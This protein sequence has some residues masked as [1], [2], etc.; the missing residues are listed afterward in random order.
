MVSAV[1]AIA[2]DYDGTLTETDRPDPE[3]LEAIREVRLLGRVV[4][5]VT[6]RILSEL[7][8]VFP[9]V[10]EEFDAI[11]A[12]NGAVLSDAEGVHDL[13]EPV[14]PELV[15]SLVHRDIPVRTGRVL[16]ACDA[17]YA[18]QVLEDIARLELDAQ[19]VRNRA[20][21][22]V[23][24]GGVTKGI[25]LTRALGNLG[26]SRHSTMAVG[27][28]ENDHHLLAVCEL[29][30]AVA[31][32]VDA[33]KR[34]ADLVLTEPNGAG[35]VELLRGPLV[36]GTET[37]PP[38]GWKLTLGC[39]PSGDP[40]QIPASQVNILLTGGSTSGKSY[41]AGLLVE[42]L[43]GMDY[44]VLVID[45]EGDHQGL[46]GRRGILGV[47]GKEPLPSPE[48]L[49]A[50]LRHRFSSVV[51]DLSQHDPHAQRHYLQHIAPGILAQRAVTGLPHWVFFD[52]AHA[53]PLG[54]GLWADALEEGATGFCHSTYRPHTLPAIV[55]DAA[56]VFVLSAG[57]GTGSLEARRYV[58]QTA[59]VREEALVR[60]L[61]AGRGH[62]VVVAPQVRQPVT[63][64]RVAERIS[65][66]VR[67][68]HKYIHGELP[69]ALRFYFGTADEPRVAANLR[70]FHRHL[71][72]C[73]AWTVEAHARRHDFSNWI[74]LVLQDEELA[75]VIGAFE[76]RLRA[77]EQPA[78]AVRDAILLAI[79][80]RYLE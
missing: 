34:R 4:V 74:R 18:E 69:E 44:G 47:G 80:G 64:F 32:A 25:G 50:L 7:R 72:T 23:L 57:D 6:G 16:L 70:E 65:G 75:D 52:E 60:G 61:E 41:V 22:M 77:G 31:N 58:A 12:E 24:P 20:A 71:G 36:R 35:I 33:L 2:F 76:R 37:L 48:A 59:E 28:A 38:S 5:L 3:V 67:H 8:T 68:W 11:V 10:D 21:L 53:L 14:A 45:L 42:Q 46:A 15:R 49:A 62:G 51:L 40:V 26:V 55:R 63:A 1:Q 17:E 30:V 43:A 13:A 66:H 39:D 56:G 54:L 73:V 9:E 79:E 27:D 78:P 19:V 29:G